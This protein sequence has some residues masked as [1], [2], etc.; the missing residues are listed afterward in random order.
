M[1]YSLYAYVEDEWIYIDSFSSLGEAQFYG[2]SQ[3]NNLGWKVEF[4]EV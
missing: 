4:E 3:F 1:W 2:S